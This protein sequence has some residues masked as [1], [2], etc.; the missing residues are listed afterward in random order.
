MRTIG[1]R[2]LKAELSRVLRD[3]QRGDTVL[4]TDRGRVVAE[5]R[6]RHLHTVDIVTSNYHTH[7]SGLIYHALAPDL[8]VHLVAAPDEY[9]TPDG[10]WKT[11]EGTKKFIQEWTKTVAN[12]FGV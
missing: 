9:F 3:V 7:R 12:W 4:V 6:K 2:E 8:E 5:L 1:I 10:W 11:H